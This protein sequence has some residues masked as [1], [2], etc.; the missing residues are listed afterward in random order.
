MTTPFADAEP[1]PGREAVPGRREDPGV[2]NLKAGSAV[3]VTS[4]AVLVLEVL[5]GRL[6]APYV[7]V[8]IHTFTATIGTVLAGIAAGSWAGGWL[9]DRHEPRRML[10]PTLALAGV[11]TWLALP[12]V[13]ALGPGATNAPV[14]IIALVTAAFLLPAAVL[15]AVSPMVAKLRLTR[16][17]ETGAV[18]GGLSAV[19]TIGALAGTYVTGFVLVA[20]L[21][22]RSVIVG[23]GLILVAAGAAV[24]IAVARRRPSPAAVVVVGAAAALAATSTS[25]CEFETEYFCV[26]IEADP[27]H[28]SG[29]SLYLDDLR[30][31]YVD[32]DDPTRLAIRYTRII[33]DVAAA[34]PADDLRAVHLGGGGFSVPRHLL[35]L[36]P[37]SEHLVIEIDPD[38][39]AI[40]AAEL[41]LLERPRLRVHV[42]DAR[43]AVVELGD[44]VTDLVVGDAFAS[45]AVPWHLTTVEFVAEI[46][47]ILAPGGVYVMNVVDGGASDFARAEL[48]TLAER[49]DHLAVV[50]PPSGIPERG[51][52]NQLLIASDAPL[53]DLDLDPGDGVVVRG[54]ALDD[55][56][57]DARP[58]VDDFAPVDTLISH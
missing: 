8:S 27:A 17:E 44:D 35:A 54:A 23:L 45:L 36:R 20:V 30:H 7:G 43:P 24:W 57:G 39:V 6:L 15:S 3:F 37:E 22:T 31:A 34:L 32:L 53:G 48:A 19:G 4:A 47:R 33:A 11:T 10:G 42:G 1:E 40:A 41:G 9:A 14:D 5:A 13:A 58:L 18:V 16:L 28:P 2:S 21:P 49:F 56:V 12:I 26:Q 38:L 25:P 52:V 50:H 55:F 51:A 29:R 46:E